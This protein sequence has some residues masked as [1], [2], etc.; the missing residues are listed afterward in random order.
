LP[1]FKPDL[2]YYFNDLLQ[3]GKSV[4]VAARMNPGISL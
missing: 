2:K 3:R 4:R 1:N